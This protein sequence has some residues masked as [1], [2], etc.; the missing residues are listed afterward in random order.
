MNSL[1]RWI[2]VCVLLALCSC[3]GDG[4][5]DG[6]PAA[7][8]P[9]PPTAQGIGPAGG[10][11]S[12][13]SGAQVVVP[14]NALA[15]TVDIQI[16]QSSAGAPAMPSGMTAAGEVFAFTPHGTTFA[17]PATLTIPLDAAQ[18]PAGTAVVLLKTDAAQTA[19]EAVPGATVG[20]S[21]IT[22][23]VTS[24]SWLRAAFATRSL[25][26]RSRAT[27]I[28]T[29]S[30]YSVAVRGGNLWLWGT[31]NAG[32][33]GLTTSCVQAN[34]LDAPCRIVGP[35]SIEAVAAGGGFVVALR[36]DGQVI[37]FGAVPGGGGSVV[38]ADA[39]QPIAGL[40]GVRQVAAG[41]QHA[42]ALM[43]DGTVMSWGASGLLGDGTAIGGPT[44]RPVV[45]GAPGSSA[46]GGVVAIAA[47]GNRSLALT[48][49]GNVWTWGEDGP[50][51]GLGGG[52]N[53][54]YEVLSATRLT[55][56]SG[57]TGIAAGAYSSLFGEGNGTTW[58]AG[59][60][61]KVSQPLAHTTPASIYTELN[62]A[63]TAAAGVSTMTASSTAP[64]S[65]VVHADGT[66]AG[67]GTPSE[68]NAIAAP[69]GTGIVEIAAGNGAHALMV[70]SAGNVWAWG[71]NSFGQI[72]DG[73]RTDRMAPVQVPGIN[74][75]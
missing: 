62:N 30:Q 45:T 33:S 49:G 29:G 56:L 75:N 9:N 59:N 12:D 70:D 73:T 55:T 8:N 36:S 51:L 74:L 66:L 61:L 63:A 42:L 39:A 22:A 6:A 3:G 50:G 58:Y 27:R 11:V 7:G 46:L 32:I 20:G 15:Q 52:A 25:N 4:D 10:T 67:L 34:S 26:V 18:V 1:L 53:V 2:G 40:T 37:Q 31:L 44:P 72:G 64:W 24:F 41:W 47:A 69:A 23:P 28:A 57:I 14:P 21:Q 48:A 71:Q 43:S 65:I 16:A 60:R 5:G 19:W 13:A 38:N 68:V 17:T 35:S 54:P